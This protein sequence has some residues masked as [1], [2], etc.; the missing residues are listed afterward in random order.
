MEMNSNNNISSN[1]ERLALAMEV[2]TDG[3]WDLGTILMVNA[4]HS[5]RKTF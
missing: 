1:T 4:I 2:A 5:T 3:I